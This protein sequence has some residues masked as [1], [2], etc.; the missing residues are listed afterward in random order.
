M[1]F[2]ME[3]FVLAS[4]LVYLAYKVLGAQH[5][6]YGIE[7]FAEAVPFQNVIWFWAL[8]A[9]FLIIY[10]GIARRDEMISKIHREFSGA[11]W[12]ALKGKFTEARRQNV[13]LVFA[14][15]VFVLIIAVSIF[16]YL[17]P[18]VNIVAAPYNYIAFLA[19]LAFSIFL[20][21]KTREFRESFYGPSL[22][23]RVVMNPEDH[24]AFRRVTSPQTGSI[25]IASKH[26]YDRIAHKKPAVLM[27]Q[28]VQDLVEAA[29]K[30]IHAKKKASAAKKPKKRR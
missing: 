12:T 29:E 18:E 5:T 14:E 21:S 9:F 8:L 3:E 22:A 15:F 10:F 4:L 19:F 6:E 27:K 20:Y 28:S 2:I 17:D 1:L 25:R 11:L 24:H 7:F 26:H 30:D 13:A 23:K 16:I